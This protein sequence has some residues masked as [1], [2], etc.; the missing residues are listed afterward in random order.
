MKYTSNFDYGLFW[1]WS[2]YVCQDA[3]SNPCLPEHADTSAVVQC[4]TTALFGE[5]SRM[6]VVI[7]SFDGKRELNRKSA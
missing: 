5:D 2:P 6:F 7:A 1:Y 3:N 4:E